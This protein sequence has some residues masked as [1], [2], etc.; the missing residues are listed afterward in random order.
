VERSDV[1]LLRPAEVVELLGVSRSW[2]YDAANS[3]RIPCVRLGSSDGPVRFRLR[4][5]EAWI[6]EGRVV[7]PHERGVG[8]REPAST[9]S[10][11]S[12]RRPDPAAGEALTQLR[13]LPAEGSDAPDGTSPR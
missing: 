4:E 7:P 10:G 11:A 9:D 8:R 1:Y 13:L 2:L 12:R 5:L 6:D 3:G